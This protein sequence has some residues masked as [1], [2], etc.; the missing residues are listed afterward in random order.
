[1]DWPSGSSDILSIGASI[2]VMLG[3]VPILKEGHRARINLSVWLV[4]TANAWLAGVGNLF[5]EQKGASAIY[6]VLN[7]VILSPVLFFNLKRGVWGA[8]PAWHKAAAIVLPI[9]TA[10]GVILGG[11]YATWAAVGVSLLLSTQLIE[12]GWRKISREHILTWTWFFLADGSALLFGWARADAS[13][14]A[15][16]LVWVLQCALVIM[17]EIKNRAEERA[18]EAG[19]YPKLHRTA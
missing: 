19:K 4:I 1:M 15:L 8:L 12:S 10:A 3:V 6:M 14:R 16:L 13:L 11:E 2:F 5:A 7:A 17:I 18:E 9:G